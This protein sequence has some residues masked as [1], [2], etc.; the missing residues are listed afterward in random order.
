MPGFGTQQANLVSVVRMTYS[1]LLIEST[2]AQ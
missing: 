2:E 1:I